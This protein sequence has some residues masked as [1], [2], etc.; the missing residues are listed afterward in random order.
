[1]LER[2]FVGLHS[3][4]VSQAGAGIAKK[5]LAHRQTRAPLIMSGLQITRVNRKMGYLR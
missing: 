4:F 1:M 2:L 3:A 5:T